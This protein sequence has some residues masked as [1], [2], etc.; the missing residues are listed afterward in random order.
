[1]LLHQ[2]DP[3]ELREDMG[4]IERA[5]ERRIP[6]LVEFKDIRG[7]FHNH[8]TYS[9][10]NASLEEMVRTAS[11]A[12]YEY[13][14]ISDHSRSAK[15]ANGMEIERIWEQ[16]REIET[17]Q[18]E[19]PRM[20]LFKGIECDILPD[21]SLDYPDKILSSFDF[22]IASIH[23]N[24]QMAEREMTQRIIRGIQNPHVTIL[25]HP[26]GRLLLSR[27]AYALDL[28][29]VIVAAGKSGVIL[30]LNAHPYRLDLDWRMG[31]YAKE[32]GCSISINPDAH[33]LEGIKAVVYG[34]GIARK[35]WFTREEVFN[36]KTATAMKKELSKRKKDRQCL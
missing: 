24:F 17:L 21:G 10:G 27:E 19:Y 34:V 5:K 18:K 1:M 3:F 9:D 28:R 4:E 8:T 14:G 32:Q 36:T 29:E 25:G 23:S 2:S 15:Y 16:H 13:I 20:T 6:R 31:L 12:G 22:V 30:E 7:I 26:T 35:G 11:K 33:S